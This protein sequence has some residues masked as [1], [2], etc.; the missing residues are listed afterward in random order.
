MSKQ[1]VIATVLGV[2]LALAGVFLLSRP[3]SIQHWMLNRYHTWSGTARWNPLLTF[4]QSDEY[5]V[6]LRVCG[7]ICLCMAV[8]AVWSVLRS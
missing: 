3:Q 1:S 7:A 5:L 2:V 6:S 8:I 4:M